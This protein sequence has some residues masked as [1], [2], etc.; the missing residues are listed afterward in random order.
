MIQH[1]S[2][3]ELN[4]IYIVEVNVICK[5]IFFIIFGDQS[6][7]QLH[8]HATGLKQFLYYFFQIKTNYFYLTVGSFTPLQS[9][10]SIND[11][12]FGTLLRMVFDLFIV[13][14]KYKSIQK[15]SIISSFWIYCCIFIYQL[16][17]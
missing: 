16:I 17:R 8:Q 14:F 15:T 7:Q 6:C 12:I 5:S 2:Q 9:Y 11:L 10:E 4:F 3:V 13:W 1:F